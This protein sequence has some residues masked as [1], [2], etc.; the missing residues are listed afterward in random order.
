MNTTDILHW[1]TDTLEPVLTGQI[2]TREGESGEGLALL[3]AD[4]DRI[5]DFV[6]ES[7]KLPEIRGASQVIRDLTGDGT[8]TSLTA[9]LIEY[10]L[11][12]SCVIYAG[13]GSLLALVP[14]AIARQVGA[15]IETRYARATGSATMTAIALPAQTTRLAN[16]FGEHVRLAGLRL[17]AAK[18][19]RAITPHFEV[20]PLGR[21]CASCG[22]R[23]AGEND[24]RLNEPRYLCWV[25]QNK[26]RQADRLE[27]EHKF[28]RSLM[29]GDFYLSDRPEGT[30]GLRRAGDLTDI[31][32]ASHDRL[33]GLIYVDGDGVGNMLYG[34]ETIHDFQSR[35]RALTATLESVVLRAL[36]R[37]L[38]PAG[39]YH[40]FEIVAIGG[41][42]AVLFVPGDTALVVAMEICET[43]STELGRQ[44]WD[45][46]PTMSAGVIISHEHNPVRFMREMAD[47][48]LR[49]AKKRSHRDGGG[50]LDFALLKSQ[51]TLATGLETLRKQAYGYNIS[52]REHAL[53][54][55]RPFSL[56]EMRQVMT[57]ARLLQ[58]TGFARAQSQRLREVLRETGRL[59]RLWPWLYY[60]R[61]KHRM[62]LRHRA[63]LNRIESDWETGSDHDYPLW[64]WLPQP[65]NGQNAR[66][67]S[68]WEDLHEVRELLP[69]TEP[70]EVQSEI[71][72]HLEA[73]ASAAHDLEADD[74]DRN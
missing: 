7:V 65:G 70:P 9:V 39:D 3:S 4:A 67:R 33:V 63:V 19:S 23:P 54:T 14:Q 6:F 55:G 73:V 53:L 12:D 15:E 71:D 2:P 32:A 22:A 42:D 69:R 21:R 34:S 17:R 58:Q 8:E 44:G 10:G 46:S 13:G 43:F 5:K 74:E 61:Q 47:Q 38:R 60:H 66:F 59:G 45:P 56:A 64:P 25:C 35:S 51:S 29:Q 30:T 36:A 16:H 62:S 27:Y 26:I 11:P 24:L 41:D 49:S 18:Q 40:A 37:R 48:L 31:A 1:V 28:E 72:K 50:A 52:D 20:T 68:V 57:G